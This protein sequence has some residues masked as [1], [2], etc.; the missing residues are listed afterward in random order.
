MN[1]S[2]SSEAAA[3]GKRPVSAR[4]TWWLNEGTSTLDFEAFLEPDDFLLV[5][6]FKLLREVM[7]FLN[8]PM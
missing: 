5:F 3:R 8:Q 7:I 6:C 4:R 1:S 2:I